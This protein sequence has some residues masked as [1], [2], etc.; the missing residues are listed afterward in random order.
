MSPA[1]RASAPVRTLALVIAFVVVLAV[2][3][4]ALRE[5]LKGDRAAADATGALVLT[6][7]LAVTAVLVIRRLRR[8]T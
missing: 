7:A 5:I 2:D 4:S 3:W 8:R 1:E 6:A